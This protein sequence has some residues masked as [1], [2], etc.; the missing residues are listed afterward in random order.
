MTIFLCASLTIFVF[1]VFLAIFEFFYKLK[2][3][4]NRWFNSIN[5]LIVGTFL[6]GLL[7]FLP[8]YWDF[9]GADKGISHYFKTLLIAIHHTIRLFVIDSDFEIIKNACGPE[10]NLYSIFASIIYVVAPVLTFG[11]VLSFFGNVTTKIKYLFCIKKKVYV[12]SEVNKKSLALAKSINENY[13]KNAFVIFTNY[14][15]E[16]I[17]SEDLEEIKNVKAIYLKKDILSLHVAKYHY[18]L[19]TIF[20]LSENESKNIVQSLN[21]VDTY[22]E[23][24]NSLLYVFSNQI[25]GEALIS[26]INNNIDGMRVR[27]ISDTK[28]LM[29]IIFNKRGHLLF[30]NAINLGEEKLISAVIIGMGEYGF[31]MAKNLPWFCQ[32]PGYKAIISCFDKEKNVKEKFEAFAPD[33]INDKYNNKFDDSGEAQYDLRIHDE[34]DIKSN[35][36]E[37]RIKEIGHVSYVFIAFGNDDT[38]IRTAIYLRSLFEKLNMHPTIQT[39]VNNSDYVNALSKIQ[40]FKNQ[41]YN[42]DFIDDLHDLYR[43]GC[44]IDSD[45]VQEALGRHLKWGK[46]SVFWQYEYN[47]LSSIASVLHKKMKIHCQVPGILKEPKDRTEEEK[48]TI[49]KLEHRRWNAYMRSI[50]YTTF[51]GN[52]KKNDLAKLH[53]LLVSFDDLSPEEQAK[54]DD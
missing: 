22:G 51:E 50:G 32:M 18:S 37:K 7:L 35:E 52:D 14:K 11:I 26:N 42:I 1:S 28:A 46:E 6:T 45:L 54:D 3:K 31:E 24:K 43:V 17:S 41:E 23:D 29:H 38:N 21:I 40:N 19:L 47:Y 8:I 13:K 15:E 39:V 2:N 34:V 5:I 16:T 49:R 48:L 30:D 9:F 25:E 44:I 12:F 27:R 33:L 20:L 10:N 53:P 4:K 36:F